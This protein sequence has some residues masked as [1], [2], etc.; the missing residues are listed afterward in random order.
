VGNPRQEARFSKSFWVP[1]PGATMGSRFGTRAERRRRLLLL[2][3]LLLLLGGVLLR[4]LVAL[5]VLGVNVLIYY[6]IK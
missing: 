6:L 1:N 2:L 4:V 3:L 5:L